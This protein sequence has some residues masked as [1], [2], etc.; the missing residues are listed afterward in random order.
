MS[1]ELYFDRNAEG[2]PKLVEAGKCMGRDYAI[3][4]YGTHPCAYVA[5]LGDDTRDFEEMDA[6]E[7]VNGGITFGIGR[8]QSNRLPPFGP[9][10]IEA[11]YGAIGWDYAH[12]NDYFHVPESEKLPENLREINEGRKKWTLPEIEAEVLAMCKWLEGRKGK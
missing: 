10:A 4:S 3:V 5:L 2:G 7:A 1:G 11:P 6:L 8:L 12:G 9:K